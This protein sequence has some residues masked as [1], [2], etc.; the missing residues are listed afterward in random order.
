M[1]AQT[2]GPDA[3]E[4]D[5]GM[6]ATNE[7]SIEADAASSDD[8]L[9]SVNRPVYNFN[10]TLDKAILEPIAKGYVEITPRL[11]RTGITNIYENA[12]YLNVILNDILQGKFEQAGADFTRF[13]FNTTL[14]LAGLVDIG[15]AVGLEKHEEDFGQTLAKWGSG[16]GAYLVIPLLGPNTVRDTP[17]YG[18][19]LVTNPLFYV[20]IA[21]AILIP[22][23]AVGIINKRA[24]LLDAT[25]LR[26]EAAVD[27][28]TFTREAY[29]QRRAFL[30]YD[31]HPPAEHYDVDE[32]IEQEG[33]ED[34]EFDDILFIK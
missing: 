3:A 28:Y 9:E 25:R 4:V 8:P 24:N 22:V 11:V 23:A 31:G 20:S 19:A 1:G 7:G 34:E 33:T 14:G 2:T 12:A 21:N 6:E 32:F 26:D 16:E 30:I 13:V 17:D 10:D 5:A 27:P 15:T 18:T 29:R